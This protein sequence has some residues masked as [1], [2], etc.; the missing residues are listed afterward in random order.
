MIPEIIISCHIYYVKKRMKDKNSLPSLT[1][2]VK[3]RKTQHG[4]GENSAFYDK[5]RADYVREGKSCSFFA[6]INVYEI[7]ALHEIKRLVKE[8][9]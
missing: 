5:K 8:G 1:V 3:K 6:I 4:M 7:C 2:W 9:K